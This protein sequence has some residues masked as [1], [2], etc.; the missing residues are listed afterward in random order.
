MNANQ[1]RRNRKR[2]DLGGVTSPA[3]AASIAARLSK[4]IEKRKPPQQPKTAKTFVV[5]GIRYP[6]QVRLRVLR[7]RR[8]PPP[9]PSPPVTSFVV[10][11]R[12]NR[13]INCE[14][15]KIVCI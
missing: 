14:L 9:H 2:S 7:A 13:M 3:M 12:R 11:D 1:R 8:T 15:V 6:V 4:K 10:V 5:G